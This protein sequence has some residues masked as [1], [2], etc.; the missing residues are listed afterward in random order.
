MPVM[1][2]TFDANAAIDGTYFYHTDHLATPRALTAA[3]TGLVAWRAWYEPYGKM[4]EDCGVDGDEPCGLWQPVRFPGQWEDVDTG[5]YYNWHRFYL[6]E[7]G[8]YNREDP[9]FGVGAG[10]WGYGSGNPVVLMDPMGLDTSIVEHLMGFNDAMENEIFNLLD[11]P[12]DAGEDAAQMAAGLVDNFSF[13][14]F[15][16][17][18]IDW[19]E[20][21]FNDQF[22]DKNSPAY[23]TGYWGPT[24]KA[25]AKLLARLAGKVPAL[26]AGAGKLLKGAGKCG[27]PGINA[28]KG[29]KPRVKKLGPH[30]EAQGPHTTF[31]VDAQTGKVTGHAE[32]HPNPKNPTGFDQ[33]KRVDTQ[34]AN[35]HSHGGVPT[36]HTHSKGSVRPS[37]LEE[38]PL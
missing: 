28:A 23:Q 33:V 9:I 37:T 24:A 7:W 38:L 14:L 10:L 27:K 4:H 6:P 15:D 16:G 11:D 34:Y 36:P 25:G 17:L 32:W 31:K 2:V 13:D 12:Y 29:A 21:V 26:I 8:L 22:V 20:Y 5:F 35:P 1:L 30:P 3:D 19:G 18:R